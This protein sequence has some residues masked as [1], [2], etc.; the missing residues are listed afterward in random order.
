M[1]VRAVVL[2]AIA[3]SRLKTLTSIDLCSAS[4]ASE[5][6]HDEAAAVLDLIRACDDGSKRIVIDL[7]R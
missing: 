6:S 1:K 7:T 4:P 3:Y 5:N 2:K